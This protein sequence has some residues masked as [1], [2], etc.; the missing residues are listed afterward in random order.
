MQPIA[1]AA[2]VSKGRAR[3]GRIITGLVA[4]FLTF[5][6]VTK[7]MQEPHTV[8]AAA[9]MGF[10]AHTIV[11]I[12]ACLLTCLVIHLIPRTSAVGAI[13]LTGYLGGAVATNVHSGLP[14]VMWLFPAAFGVLVW[15]GLLLRNPRLEVL[16]AP[17]R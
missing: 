5:D 10:S 8:Q 14:V 6:A 3:T 4:V 17:T 9:Q 13:L 12:G 15:I 1:E 16:V 2:T 7:I 11:G